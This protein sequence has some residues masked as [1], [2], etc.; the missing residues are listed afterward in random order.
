M[1]YVKP[2]RPT[3]KSEGA[4]LVESAPPEIWEDWENDLP[5]HPVYRYRE[6]KPVIDMSKYPDKTKYC[7][8]EVYENIISVTFKDN[9]EEDIHVFVEKYIRANNLTGEVSFMFDDDCYKI[10][11]YEVEDNCVNA[12]RLVGENLSDE[13]VYIMQDLRNVDEETVVLDESG[14]GRL[15]KTGTPESTDIGSDVGRDIGIFVVTNIKDGEHYREVASLYEK[16]YKCFT[17]LQAESALL[18]KKPV[19]LSKEQENTLRQ[20]TRTG[21]TSMELKMDDGSIMEIRLEKE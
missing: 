2:V 4:K 11:I 12:L 8:L 16:G 10:I 18:T 3:R 20:W 9:K 21:R 14:F 17:Y 6:Y 7:L 13:Y 19:T 5:I 1:K 15:Y